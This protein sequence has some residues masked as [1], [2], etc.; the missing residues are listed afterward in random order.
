[1]RKPKLLTTSVLSG[2][3]LAM[4]LSM[5]PQEAEAG[6]LGDAWDIVSGWFGGGSTSGPPFVGYSNPD[7]QYATGQY[8]N[9]AEACA[10]RNASANVQGD[11]EA[12]CANC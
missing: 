11:G 4:T 3:I 2:M 9:R 6:W 7:C 5:A 10:D 1:M 12:S 8:A